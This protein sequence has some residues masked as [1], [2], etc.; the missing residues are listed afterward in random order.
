MNPAERIALGTTGLAV[1]RLGLGTAPLGGL[2]ARVTD[3]DAPQ[4]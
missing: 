4:V 1:T 3:A 2:F